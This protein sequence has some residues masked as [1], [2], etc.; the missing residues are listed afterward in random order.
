[1]DPAS[2]AA[3]HKETAD[4]HMMFPPAASA[5]ADQTRQAKPWCTGDFSTALVGFPIEPSWPGDSIGAHLRRAREGRGLKKTG[6]T[7]LMDVCQH[8][9]VA[10]E[11]GEKQ[12]P[13]AATR[14]RSLP[15]I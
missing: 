13:F 12:S 5:A 9:V 4:F 2:N 7:A 11:A 15:W 10:W 14:D 6:A 3:R 8:S 1:V